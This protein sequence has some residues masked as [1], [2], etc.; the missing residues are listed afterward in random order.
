MNKIILKEDPES[1]TPNNKIKLR[2]GMAW[3]NLNDT[4][5]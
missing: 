5:L 3:S 2:K 1:S 4:V